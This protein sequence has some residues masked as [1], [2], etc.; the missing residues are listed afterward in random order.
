MRK[1]NNEPPDSPSS[2]GEHGIHNKSMSIVERLR[3]KMNDLHANVGNQLK[4]LDAKMTLLG[5]KVDK[6]QRDVSCMY[7]QSMHIYTRN[8][9]K[10]CLLPFCSCL[11]YITSEY[12]GIFLQ[13]LERMVHI[14]YA[15]GQQLCSA[16]KHSMN[17]N[18]LC[19]EDLSLLHPLRPLDNINNRK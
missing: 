19:L 7:L 8:P 17:K 2:D 9:T 10:A 12:R 4:L 13:N 18:S 15:L 1:R 11:C 14:T 3:R 6:I 5:T 16:A